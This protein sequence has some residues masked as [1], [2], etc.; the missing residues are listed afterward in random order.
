MTFRYAA[1]TSLPNFPFMSSLSLQ[2]IVQKCECFGFLIGHSDMLF[3][4]VR[5]I[6]VHLCA[7][8]NHSAALQQL[9]LTFVQLFVFVHYQS[10]RFHQRLRQPSDFVV[11]LPF[12]TLFLFQLFNEFVDN[13]LILGLHLKE[14]FVL[15]L[16][17]IQ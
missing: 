15:T 9:H 2:H 17:V 13:N 5:T 6:A 4:D 12:H 1:V 16:R 14:Q 11:H 3:A 10:F 7:A 8:L